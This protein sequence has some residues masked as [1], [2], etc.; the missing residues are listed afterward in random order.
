MKITPANKAADG[1]QAAP[2]HPQEHAES[3]EENV[4]GDPGVDGHSQ[5]QA[6]V[7]PV[8]GIKERRLEAA[9]ERSAAVDVRIPEREVTNAQLVEAEF[10]PVNELQGDVPVDVREDQ[11]TAEKR[12]AKRG[13]GQRQQEQRGERVH[14]RIACPRG[15]PK[16]GDA[17]EGRPARVLLLG[18]H[19]LN[20]AGPGWSV[21]AFQPGN[22][23]PSSRSRSQR[24]RPEGLP[25]LS[26]KARV[27]LR[28]ETGRPAPPPVCRCRPPFAPRG[29]PPAGCGIR[30]IPERR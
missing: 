21:D 28:T 23:M 26:D 15:E 7:Q 2:P 22:Q 1:M 12:G 20:L 16:G 19:R 6:Q 14:T 5:G 13:D 29:T 4:Q 11:F 10:A 9:E 27:H 3:R 8:R 24:M 30:T 17:K 18:T 25:T